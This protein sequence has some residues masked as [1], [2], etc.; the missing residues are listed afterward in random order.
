MNYRLNQIYYTRY[1]LTAKLFEIKEFACYYEIDYSFTGRNYLTVDVLE[2]WSWETKPIAIS[3]AFLL[4]Y[5]TSKTAEQNAKP[6][7]RWQLVFEKLNPITIGE[8]KAKTPKEQAAY[9][10]ETYD[11]S[12]PDPNNPDTPKEPG[13]TDLKSGALID[14][15]GSLK[16]L[17]ASSTTTGKRNILIVILVV[18]FS[19]VAFVAFWAMKKAK[20]KA[21][22]AAAKYGKYA[23]NVVDIVS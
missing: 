15:T 12:T 2:S 22:I 1:P 18:I 8:W 21:E 19:A 14:N 3:A 20:G 6:D 10:G 11:P 7:E 13:T 4:P 16:G 23:Q 9:L 17:F 5:D